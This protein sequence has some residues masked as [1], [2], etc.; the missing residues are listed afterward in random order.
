[1]FTASNLR[2]ARASFD[3]LRPRRVLRRA[4]AP[5][6][7]RISARDHTMV[8]SAQLDHTCDVISQSQRHPKT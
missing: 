1:M 6:A 4:A 3:A 7:F 8:M 2:V 5:P